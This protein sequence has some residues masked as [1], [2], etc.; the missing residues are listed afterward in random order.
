MQ[1]FICN[2][3]SVKGE[4]DLTLSQLKTKGK[5]FIEKQ[6]SAS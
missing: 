4:R 3:S 5:L 6:Y 1:S 2:D